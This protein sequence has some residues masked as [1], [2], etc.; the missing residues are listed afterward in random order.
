MKSSNNDFNDPSKSTII[1]RNVISSG[2]F[3]PK[4]IQQQILVLLIFCTGLVSSFAATLTVTTGSDS[5]AGSLR[6]QIAAAASGDIIVF[7]GVTTVTLTS[8]ELVINKNLTINGG[9]GVTITRSGSTL[10]RIFNITAGTVTLNNLTISNGNANG[11]S[12]GGI[13]SVS[14]TT[15]T[16]NTCVITGNQSGQGGGIQADGTMSLTNCRISNNNTSGGEGGGVAAFG[17]SI[18]FTGCTINNNT[19]PFYGGLFI[20]AAGI[21]FSMTN[22][23]ISG[24]SG[25]GIIYGN[26]SGTP[27]AM[28]TNCTITGNTWGL[29]MSSG[30]VLLKNT[31]VAKNLSQDIYSGTGFNGSVSASSS[32]NLI[33]NAG[34][35]GGLTN[36][37]NNNQVGVANP[38]LIALASNGGPTQTHALAPC[39]PAINAGTGVGAPTTDQRGSSRVGAVDVG[40]FEYQSAPSY[41]QCYLY[42]HQRMQW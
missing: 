40:A 42:G 25:N 39:S 16:L 32:Y 12:G 5:G 18:S 29:L 22:C 20:S 37:V 34:S 15:V 9:S 30:T 3:R 31:I 19:A 41:D 4:R 28:L 10:F 17:P 33:G 23:T 36:G 21:A 11:G 7:S 14:G 13:Y 35:G 26:T 8:A 27:A 2:A 24:N 38:G 1:L 6:N